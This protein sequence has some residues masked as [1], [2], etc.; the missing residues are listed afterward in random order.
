MTTDDPFLARVEHLLEVGDAAIR[1]DHN[2]GEQLEAYRQRWLMTPEEAFRQDE[3]RPRIQ[4]F[5]TG[6]KTL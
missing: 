6:V 5:P 4:R 3:S 2:W 1:R